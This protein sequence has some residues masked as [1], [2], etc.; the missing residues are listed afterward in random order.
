[1][2]GDPINFQKLIVDGIKEIIGVDDNQYEAETKW[3]MAVDKK[4]PYIEI[5]VTQGKGK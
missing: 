3:Q 1:M 5:T 2:L 4:K